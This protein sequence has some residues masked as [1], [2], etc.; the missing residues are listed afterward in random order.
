M[1]ESIVF[2]PT[3]DDRQ[4]DREVDSV[5]DALAETGTISP[6]VDTSGL[7]DVQLG[8]SGGGMG[9]GGD[10][11]QNIADLV[12]MADYRNRLLE[13][14]L[15]EIQAGGGGGDGDGGGNR[16][17]NM[18]GGGGLGGLLGLGLGAAGGLG[19]GLGGGL[20]S[21][22]GRGNL[23]GNIGGRIKSIIQGIRERIPSPDD[24]IPDIPDPASLLPDLNLGAGAL[25][26]GVGGVLSGL[27]AGGRSAIGG[28]GRFL[29]GLSRGVAGG[30]SSIAAIPSVALANL[31]GQGITDIIPDSLKKGTGVSG[32]GPTMALTGPLDGLFPGLFG[33][34][35][36]AGTPGMRSAAQERDSRFRND[37]AANPSQVQTNPNFNVDLSIDPSGLNDLRRDLKREL[38]NDLVPQ[39]VSQVERELSIGLGGN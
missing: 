39:V 18:L 10:V 4:L 21:Q 29:G 8:A 38:E 2:G 36:Q 34:G 30:L 19:L 1:D 12:P 6:D 7:G 33:G 31:E 15:D 23:S 37:P 25:A 26:G 3:I 22:T 24:L 28:A 32:G 20:L 16:L 5:N 9:P 17:R 11:G 35:G 27:V 14:I 13:D